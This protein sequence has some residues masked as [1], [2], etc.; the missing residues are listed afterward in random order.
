M[1]WHPGGWDFSF[2]SI[3]RQF[4]AFEINIHCIYFYTYKL[5]N[6]NRFDVLMVLSRV[7]IN[8][9]MYMYV[10]MYKLN[11]FNFSC[12]SDEEGPEGGVPIPFPS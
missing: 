1:I 10:C 2:V 7:K 4:S 8:L 11:Y 5:V 12:T 9:C 6:S 3:W